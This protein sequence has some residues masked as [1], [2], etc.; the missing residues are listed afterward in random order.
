MSTEEVTVSLSRL[1]LAKAIKTP[2]A[3]EEEAEP[4]TKS[5]IFHQAHIDAQMRNSIQNPHQ[6]QPRRKG[7]NNKQR[8]PQQQQQQQ[9]QY[10]AAP[11]MNRVRSD[12]RNHQRIQQPQQQQ[13][14]LHQQQP[15]RTSSPSGRSSL[16]SG[17]LGNI[18][19]ALRG[20]YFF[21][22]F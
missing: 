17:K 15:L 3:G 5:V 21:F 12:E 20:P 19:L 9:Q 2:D 7:N 8:Y 1:A 16:S 10:R 4:W 13:Q 18:S 22:F 11:P 6:Q 14:Q